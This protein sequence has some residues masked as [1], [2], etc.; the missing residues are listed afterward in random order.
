LKNQ[1]NFKKIIIFSILIIIVI[2]IIIFFVKKAYNSSVTGNNIGNKTVEDIKDYILNI[3][4][5]EAEIEVTVNTNKNTNKYILKQNCVMP[6][7]F[8]QEVIKPENIKNL[9]TIYDGKTLKIENTK[10]NLT[11]IYEEYENIANN[12]LFLSTFI[13]NYKND[14]GA[15]LKTN[16]EEIILECS[17][18]NNNKY[19]EKQILYISKSTGM[20]IRM[21]IKDFNKNTSVYILYNGIKINSIN[22][23]NILAFVLETKIDS[24]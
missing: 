4:S 23:E 18:Q 10:L 16:N 12:T 17:V 21:E 7:I 1:I 6:D 8:T 2:L 5:Y 15:T 19:Q 24:I 22:K 14:D 9:K 3:S 20:P 13:E 11:K